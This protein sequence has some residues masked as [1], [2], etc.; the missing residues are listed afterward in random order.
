MRF[1]YW[2]TYNKQLGHLVL[3]LVLEHE[4]D[5]IILSECNFSFSRFLEDLNKSLKNKFKFP[6]SPIT[7]PLIE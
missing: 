6:Y 5:V 4:I 7:E 2:N 3:E 1:L